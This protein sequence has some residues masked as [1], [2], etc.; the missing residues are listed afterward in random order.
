M[1]LGTLDGGS[2]NINPFQIA[3][4]Q[5]WMAQLVAVAAR[6]DKRAGD[7]MHIRSEGPG[8][9]KAISSILQ[10]VTALSS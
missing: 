4:N 8:A 2:M 10:D 7:E 1:V 9:C 5:S 6:R 3:G